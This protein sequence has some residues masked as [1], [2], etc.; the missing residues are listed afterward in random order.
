[1][2]GWHAFLKSINEE[3]KRTTPEL[4]YSERLQIA[5][6]KWKA[7]KILREN[8]PVDSENILQ[9]LGNLQE[10]HLK[11]EPTEDAVDNILA[12]IMKMKSGDFEKFISGLSWIE[13]AKF[14]T[15]IIG[16]P[17]H[18]LACRILKRLIPV[19][20]FYSYKVFYHECKEGQSVD[21]L[22]WCLY[23]LEETHHL[24]ALLDMIVSVIPNKE[25]TSETLKKMG[26]RILYDMD[27]IVEMK[28]GKSLTSSILVGN[29]LKKIP[30][31]TLEKLIRQMTT[32][33]MFLSTPNNSSFSESLWKAMTNF[34]MC[35]HV[36]NDSR[37]MH[38]LLLDDR[39]VVSPLTIRLLS[40]MGEEGEKIARKVFVGKLN[41]NITLAEQY[42]EYIIDKYGERNFMEA[43]SQTALNLCFTS[44]P[45]E[46]KSRDMIM[47]S[48]RER[49]QI[50]DANMKTK[51]LLS[52]DYFAKKIN[53]VFFSTQEEITPKDVCFQTTDNCLFSVEELAHLKKTEINPFTN[54]KLS[55]VDMARINEIN[56]AYRPILEPIT[57][58]SSMFC[59]LRLMKQFR[60]SHL[61]SLMNKSFFLGYAT[62]FSVALDKI[63]T[64]NIILN[65][66]FMY[67]Y[68]PY[69]LNPRSE[70]TDYRQGLCPLGKFLSLQ[71]EVAIRKYWQKASEPTGL[72]EERRKNFTWLLIFLMEMYG[73][74]AVNLFAYVVENFVV[75]LP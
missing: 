27:D 3:L 33:A 61:D 36:V 23:N 63:F 55:E 73:P 7:R 38:H 8:T 15:I 40:I 29:F 39:F 16:Q 62:K 48:I 52:E 60:N 66:V 9:L 68:E 47:N 51:M 20:E 45:H 19:R 34:S 18:K 30:L 31:E 74:V 35:F 13:Y 75:C 12:P 57:E 5:S 67:M 69:M 41:L 14:L 22:F 2:S 21:V 70:I 11:V 59:D 54:T 58:S 56:H 65:T 44:S 4:S 17:D 28:D 37:I 1:M 10:E 72:Y 26:M 42:C 32:K 24:V 64:S 71:D 43:V 53:E 50:Y 6:D 49:K 25:T 46:L